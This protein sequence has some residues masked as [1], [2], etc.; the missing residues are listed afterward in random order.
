MSICTN[1]LYKLS[2][3]DSHV[4]FVDWDNL[5]Y[6]FTVPH[7]WNKNWSNEIYFK[8]VG[9]VPVKEIIF[10]EVNP[11]DDCSIKEINWVN[12]CQSSKVV[13][14]VANVPIEKGGEF[15]AQ[16]M[17]S[18]KGYPKICG[19]RRCIQDQPSGFCTSPQFISGLK[20]IVKRGMVFDI[21][22]RSGSQPYQMNETIS[23]IE[24]VPHCV[25]VL[26]HMGKPNIKDNDF[27]DWSEFITKL[28]KFPN[29]YCKIS[30][31]ITEAGQHWTVDSIKPFIQHVLNSFGYHRCMF[32]S[33]WFIC[34]MNGDLNK[35]FIALTEILKDTNED[36]RILLFQDTCKRVYGIK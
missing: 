7:P 1:W 25:Y 21:C 8:E 29:V 10:M 5:Q 20:E 11:T 31:V 30:G 35:W 27:K 9:D 6:T 17:D 26:D 3:I 23:M 2:I 19:V 16:W 18:L 36:Q 28:S 33:D 24:S 13:G 12:D 14:M 15:V 22:I 32:G 34:N 4:H